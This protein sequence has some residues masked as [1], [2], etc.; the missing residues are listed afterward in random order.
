MVVSAQALSGGEG[1]GVHVFDAGVRDDSVRACFGR[2]SGISG[3]GR[4]GDG[5]RGGH[6]GAEGVKGA[7]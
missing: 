6:A 3:S 2:E 7:L 1:G 4:F 5:V